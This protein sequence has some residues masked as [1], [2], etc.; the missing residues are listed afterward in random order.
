MS[1]LRRIQCVALFLGSVVAVG[2]VLAL[3]TSTSAHA[4]PCC[5]VMVCDT[6]PPYACYHK[7]VVCPKFP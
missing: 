6:Q 4:R 5:W 2:A 3:A 7:C 1:L